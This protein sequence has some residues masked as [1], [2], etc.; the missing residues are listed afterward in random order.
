MAIHSA[1]PASSRD[2]LKD[3]HSIARRDGD[4]APFDAALHAF[5][6]EGWTYRQLGEAVG[7]SHESVRNRTKRAVE[8]GTTASKLKVPARPQA[9]EIIPTRD[10][11]PDIVA[12]LMAR[13]ASAAEP[14]GERTD[15][16]LKPA[17]AQFFHAL[18]AA[19][20][21][22]WD[23]YSIAAGIGSHPKPVF[24]FIAQ[25]ARQKKRETGPSYPAAPVENLFLAHRSRRPE[26]APVVPPE[27]EITA[28]LL[29]EE[30]RITQPDG[31]AATLHDGLLGGWYLR[32]VNRTDLEAASGLIWETLRKRLARAGY[33]TSRPR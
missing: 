23:E 22:G 8:A 24:T 16:G 33:M 1:L 12:D 28:L 6:Q 18:H 32:G 31:P 15:T 3:L 25:H 5:N 26:V 30:Q 21:A 10:L 9:L 4:S 2:E 17:V 11:H 13:Q 19:K 27:E 20:E 7:L 29:L 14:T